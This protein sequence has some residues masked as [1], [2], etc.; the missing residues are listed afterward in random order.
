MGCELGCEDRAEQGPRG[1]A[2]HYN[3]PGAGRRG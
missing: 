2:W 1:A 3:S